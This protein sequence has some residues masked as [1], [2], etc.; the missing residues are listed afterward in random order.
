MSVSRIR[1]RKLDSGIY[2]QDML[3]RGSLPANRITLGFILSSDRPGYLNGTRLGHHDLVVFAEGGAMDAYTMPAGT[4]WVTCQIPRTQLEQHDISLPS[5]AQ[6]ERYPG[7]PP[8]SMKLAAYL[9]S[10]IGPLTGRESGSGPAWQIDAEEVVQTF[11]SVFRRTHDTLEGID[12]QT[13]RLRSHQ[14][15]RALQGL[16]ETIRHHNR[17]FAY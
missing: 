8:V 4:Q 10:A 13:H 7:L 5:R 16:E 17:C 15:V 2:D 9:T 3:A 12:L 11:V 1:N 14:R 6:V